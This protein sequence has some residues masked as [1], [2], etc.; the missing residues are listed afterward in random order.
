MTISR[1]LVV[2]GFLLSLSAGPT[3]AADLPS[4]AIAI[5]DHRFH[6]AELTVP[7]GKRIELVV[8]NQDPTPEEFESTDL[9][10]EKIVPPKGK[11]SVWIGPLPPG[12]Y[13]FFGD[14]NPKTAQGKLIAK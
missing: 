3:M 10:R 1:L 6:P 11:V 14:F 9:R 2:C 13:G 7:A 12:T 8:E 5:K 4:F